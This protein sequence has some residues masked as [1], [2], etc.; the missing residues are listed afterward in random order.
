[1][2]MIER[3]SVLRAIPFLL[4]SHDVNDAI[5]SLLAG[6]YY[7]EAWIV[8]KLHKEEEDVIFEKISTNW[9]EFLEKNGNL[10]GAALM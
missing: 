1:M 7:R 9:M 8:A 2:Q 3:E 10:E 5:D 6:D 4:S